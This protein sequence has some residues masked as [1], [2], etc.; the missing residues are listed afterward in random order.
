LCVVLA[1]VLTRPL[2]QGGVQVPAYSV[3]Y[4]D[5][6]SPSLD[7]FF[8]PRV[9]QTLLG[10]APVSEDVYNFSLSAYVGL[11]AVVLAAVGVLA[12]QD[13][14]GRSFLWL[15]ACSLLLAL[16]PRLR[17]DG[18]PVLIPVPAQ[19]ERVFT[20]GVRLLAT[21]LAVTPMP[22]YY[23]LRRA[24]TI[25][26]PLP[27]LVLQWF[28]PFMNKMRYWGRFSVPLSFAV[29]VLA[30]LGVAR[31]QSWATGA[32]RELRPT[33][34]RRYAQKVQSALGVGAVAALFLE[35]AVMPYH[36][37]FSDVRRQPVDEWLARDSSEFAIAE[38]P[39]ARQGGAGPSVYRT[40]LHGKSICAGS[41]PFAPEGHRAAQAMLNAFPQE[42]T[43]ALLQKWGVKYVLAGARSY[44]Q[45]WER[46]LL[47]IEARSA[48]RLRVVL[49]DVPVYHDVGPWN[50]V[51]GYDR[52][53]PVEQ[54]Y[55]YELLD[56]P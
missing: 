3:A 26:I 21:R 23:G 56:T 30:G 17:W 18:K 16:G 20:A 25:Y 22:S 52:H 51:P 40:L 15:A 2:W 1:V 11:L 53:W 8:V 38:F 34:V 43:I 37:G 24:G 49:A 29:A 10:Q 4:V 46:T 48:L 9:L 54:A 32:N 27:T 14:K 6:I 45:D 12:R 33:I 39:Y 13:R 5:Y 50:W 28:V 31:I 55:V 44:G 47:E 41:P 36:I 7:Y 42:E 19:V 35:S